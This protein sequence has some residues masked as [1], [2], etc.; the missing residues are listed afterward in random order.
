MEYIVCRVSFG[1]MY[2]C[3]TVTKEVEPKDATPSPN[4]SPVPPPL[5]PVFLT[6]ICP[7]GCP[8]R[9]RRRGVGGWDAGP[10]LRVLR[11]FLGLTNAA[12]IRE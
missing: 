5:P 8:A 11:G 1:V 2:R 3:Q 9:V 10:D 4:L 6:R 12:S 7:W